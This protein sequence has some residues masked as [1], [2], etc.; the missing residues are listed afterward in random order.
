LGADLKGYILMV[1]LSWLVLTPALLFSQAVAQDGTSDAKQ[2]AIGPP[3]STPPAKIQR[4]EEIVLRAIQANPEL[5]PYQ[6]KTAWQKRIVVILVLISVA[7]H[8]YSYGENAAAGL[9]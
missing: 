5:A 8:R 9:A 3:R 6:I 2:R 7:V 1:K 4:P